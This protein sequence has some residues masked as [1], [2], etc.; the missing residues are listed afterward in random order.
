MSFKNK[1][2]LLYTYSLFRM[3]EE[4]TNTHKSF[5]LCTKLNKYFGHNAINYTV[6][7]LKQREVQIVTL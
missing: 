1:H 5:Y 4:L 2:I 7:S 6:D 3:E